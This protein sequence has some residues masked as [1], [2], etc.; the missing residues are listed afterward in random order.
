MYMQRDKTALLKVQSNIKTDTG[1]AFYY[2]TTNRT[3]FCFAPIESFYK[4]NLPR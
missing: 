2:R 4:V 3:I 1:T